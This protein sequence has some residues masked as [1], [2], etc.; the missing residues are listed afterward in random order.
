MTLLDRILLMRADEQAN[1]VNLAE[2]PRHIYDGQTCREPGCE[3]L[4]SYW[5]KLQMCP[6]HGDRVRNRR[7]KLREARGA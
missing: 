1:E 2:G 4:V 5:N 6:R 3:K 7:R